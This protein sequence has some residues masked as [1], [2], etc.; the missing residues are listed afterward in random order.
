[1]EERAVYW[2]DPLILANLVFKLVID[3]CANN[4]D[5]RDTELNHLEEVMGQHKHKNRPARDPFH[6]DY[7]AVTQ[8]LNFSSRTLGLVGM[9]LRV[10]QLTLEKI[11]QH[12]KGI[13]DELRTPPKD[14]QVESQSSSCTDGLEVMGELT[15]NLVDYCKTQLFRVEYQ[16]KRAKTQSTAARR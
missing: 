2:E 8:S 10:T 12:N 16:E 9:R 4:I 15:E 13:A 7:K 1:M 14:H 11:L 3:S 5:V 6:M